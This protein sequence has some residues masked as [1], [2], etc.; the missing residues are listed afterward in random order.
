MELK[1]HYKLQAN[2]K[3]PKSNL[4]ISLNNKVTSL[5]IGDAKGNGR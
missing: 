5:W 1:K 2:I 4:I 3:A